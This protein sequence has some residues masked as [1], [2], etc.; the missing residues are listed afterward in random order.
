MQTSFCSL[1]QFLH[2][3]TSSR[4]REPSSQSR[5]SSMILITSTLSTPTKN[6]LYHLGTSRTR[7]AGHLT[8]TSRTRS[9]WAPHSTRMVPYSSSSDFS[10]VRYVLLQYLRSTGGMKADTVPYGKGS[11]RYW[12]DWRISF[13]TVRYLNIQW[14]LVSTLVTADD[15]FRP[16]SR[17]AKRIGRRTLTRCGAKS[18]PPLSPTTCPR[19]RPPIANPMSL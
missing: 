4:S 11:R 15:F 6:I 14:Y 18:G 13:Y 17:P 12:Y 16:L 3:S 9:T 19:S 2:G 7:I 10:L 8:R 1:L 5:A